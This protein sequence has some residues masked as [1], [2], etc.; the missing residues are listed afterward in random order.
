MSG[1]Q[2]D[3]FMEAF[4]AMARWYN[5]R[6]RAAAVRRQMTDAG[7]PEALADE[8]VEGAAIVAAAE[9]RDLVAVVEADIR[10]RAR[11]QREGES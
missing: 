2:P 6:V 9:R 8:I 10:Y 5:S 7:V 1:E 11:L 3:S 4:N